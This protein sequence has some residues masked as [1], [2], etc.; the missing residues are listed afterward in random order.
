MTKHGTVGRYRIK[1]FFGLRHLPLRYLYEINGTINNP[2]H[3]DK[4]IPPNN[5][6]AGPVKSLPYI[7]YLWLY[8]RPLQEF[9]TMTHHIIVCPVLLRELT[10]ILKKNHATAE[11][12]PMD[13]SIHINPD[14]MERELQQNLHP[15]SS[16]N[17]TIGILVGTECQ[18]RTPLTTIAQQNKAALPKEQNCIE[19]ILGSKKTKELQQNRTAI[20]TPGWITMMKTS[21]ENST[22]RVEDARINMGWYD[23]ILLLDT[24]VVPL[25]DET[26]LEFFELTGVPIEIMVVNLNRFSRVVDRI[27][28][29]TSTT[30]DL[31]TP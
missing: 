23:R 2:P 5:M 9:Y 18:G 24:G 28:Q 19:M 31:K 13:Y 15:L 8:Y 14:L 17:E 21:I 16:A 11:I 27:L 6:G 25:D 12:H 22:W 1:L 7:R 10:A 29:D 26:I 20:M 3:K 30:G 4:I